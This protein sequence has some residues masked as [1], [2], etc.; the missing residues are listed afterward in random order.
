MVVF[1][2]ECM[3]LETNHIIEKPLQRPFI[4]CV[5]CHTF[6]QKICQISPKKWTENTVHKKMF[7]ALCVT[8]LSNLL[9]LTICPKKFH[10]FFFPE[11]EVC[12]VA[13]FELYMSKI[14]QDFPKMWQC[15]KKNVTFDNEFWYDK[16]P[17][18]VNTLENVMK[19]L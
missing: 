7:L 14:H 16:V 6:F 10:S 12:P 2:S 8:D 13:Y 11:R 9:F 17:V 19:D 3:K 5:T 15:P 1:L 4:P 18:G